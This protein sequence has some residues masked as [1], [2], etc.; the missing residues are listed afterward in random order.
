[1]RLALLRGGGV[2]GEGGR[3][4]RVARLGRLQRVRLAARLEDRAG[5]PV[6]DDA[7]LDAW[8]SG[9]AAEFLLES[10]VPVCLKGGGADS[11]AGMRQAEGQEE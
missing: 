7:G 8:F 9:E 2:V 3:R 5:R 4:R 1:M 10:V 6:Q 11:L